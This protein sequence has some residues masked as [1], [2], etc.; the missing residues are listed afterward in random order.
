MG[1]VS[2]QEVIKPAGSWPGVFLQVIIRPN[3]SD[4]PDCRFVQ[5]TRWNM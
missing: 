5:I 3:K 4:G 2:G 1:A